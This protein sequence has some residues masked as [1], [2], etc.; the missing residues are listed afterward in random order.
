MY[1]AS[2]YKGSRGTRACG[3]TPPRRRRS[4]PLEDDLAGLVVLD[5]RPGAADGDGLVAGVQH[6]RVLDGEGV[7]RGR[8]EALADVDDV[9]GLVRFEGDPWRRRTQTD[10]K[11]WTVSTAWGAA[12]AAQVATLLAAHDRDPTPFV[13]RAAELLELVLPDGPLS[14]A[15]GYLPEQVFDDG[16][17]DSGTPLGWPHALRLATVARLRESDLPQPAAAERFA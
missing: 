5:E 16:T 15:G 12:S 2:V 4:A 17:P 7:V 10:P 1:L 8:D 13:E 3:A 9:A 6:Q 14:F 11:I